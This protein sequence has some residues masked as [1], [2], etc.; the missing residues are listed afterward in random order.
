[1]ARKRH[2][3]PEGSPALPSNDADAPAAPPLPSN[4]SAE[5]LAS[6]NGS[7]NCYAE[8]QAWLQELRRYHVSGVWF[9]MGAPGLNPGVLL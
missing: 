8:A 5:S 4:P 1:M 7:V 3:E 9:I 2:L 6:R